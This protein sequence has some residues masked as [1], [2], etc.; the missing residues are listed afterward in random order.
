MNKLLTEVQDCHFLVAVSHDNKMEEEKIQF[1]RGLLSVGRMIYK[2]LCFF[3][4]GTESE[5]DISESFMFANKCGTLIC[6][7][8]II[9]CYYFPRFCLSPMEGSL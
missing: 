2:E 3:S 5:L 1:S 6:T 8:M 9:Y 7:L 4:L